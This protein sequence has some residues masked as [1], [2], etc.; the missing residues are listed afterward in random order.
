MW[1]MKVQKLTPRSP[2][3]TDIQLGL[4]KRMPKPE[5]EAFLSRKHEWENLDAFPVLK[6][7]NE[8]PRDGNLYFGANERCITTV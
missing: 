4:F 3:I 1:L 2:D 7:F 5:I 8:L 6:K